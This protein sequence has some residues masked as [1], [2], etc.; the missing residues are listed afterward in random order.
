MKKCFLLGRRDNH[1]DVFSRILSPRSEVFR[2]KV[3]GPDLGTVVARTGT[4]EAL[5]EFSVSLLEPQV[6]IDALGALDAAPTEPFDIQAYLEE[7]ERDL[8]L[9]FA[10]HEGKPS[11][12][13]EATFQQEVRE[14][15][16]IAAREISSR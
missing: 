7:A 6:F 4:R 12:L 8:G 16:V 5:N 3:C 10:Y 15:F 9:Y 11:P 14:K 1:Q 2:N 13:Y